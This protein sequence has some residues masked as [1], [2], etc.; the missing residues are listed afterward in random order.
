MK[1]RTRRILIAA[2]A[3]VFAVSLGVVAYQQLQ[4]GKNDRAIDDARRLAGVPA[5][6]KPV[7]RRPQSAPADTDEPP[8]EEPDPWADIDLEALREVNEDVAGWVAIPGTDISYPLIRP[9][10]NETYLTRSWDKTP[11]SAGS[12]FLDYR[13]A[14]EPR[15]FN[16]II[17]GH[18]MRNRTM[19]GSLRNY[20]RDGYWEQCP[21]ICLIDDEGVHYYD[22]FAA[23]EPRVTDPPFS[24]EITTEKGRQS[25]IDTALRRSVIH[26]GVEPTIGSEILTLSTCTGVGHATR[27]VIQAAL[28]TE[29]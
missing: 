13:V 10:D 6:G 14:W 9:Q 20:R 24:P 2:L 21:E 29:A 1:K 25:F 7:S 16:T 27:W 22:I 8:V 23:W 3:A 12:I 4:Y 11:T 19:F 5:V 18:N 17:Y 28:R 26:T 15:G